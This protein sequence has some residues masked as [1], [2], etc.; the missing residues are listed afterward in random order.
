MNTKENS[1]SSGKSDTS[2]SADLDRLVSLRGG[3][4]GVATKIHLEK[5]DLVNLSPVQKKVKEAKL[6][7]LLQEL[8]NL[9]NCIQK[10]R[11]DRNRNEQELLSDVERCDYYA[12][13]IHECLTVLKAPSDLPS[14]DTARSLLK[15]PVAPLPKFCSKEGE[16]LSNFFLHFEDTLARF[17]YPD[18]DRFLL[19]KQ[20]I[21][22]RALK[23]IESLEVEKQSYVHAK[24]LLVQAFASPSTLKFNTTKQFR[25]YFVFNF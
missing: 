23:L 12:D 22:G 3:R 8:S 4:R 9:D 5:D 2:D 13:L 14:I 20:Q 19:L 15:S 10:S 1:D 17:N 7:S 21:S 6:N 16:D 11:F 24:E 25:E 18:Y